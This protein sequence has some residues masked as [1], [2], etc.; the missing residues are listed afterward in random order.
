MLLPKGFVCYDYPEEKVLSLLEK[1][2]LGT[3]G[4]RYIQLDTR[5]RIQQADAPL[6]LCIERH[7]R[8][9][10][11]VTFC[12]RGANWYIRYFAFDALF[13]GSGVKHA[14][15]KKQHGLRAGI[16]DFFNARLDSGEVNRFY[17][18]IDPKNT[19]SLA[20]AAQFALHPVACLITQTFSRIKPNKSERFIQT[21]FE[22]VAPLIRQTY[23][24]HG[25]YFEDQIKHA[26]VAALKTHAIHLEVS[27]CYYSVNWRIERLPGK[28]GG[29]LTRILPVIPVLR[30]L[31]APKHHKFLVVD[32]VCFPLAQPELVEELF[33]SLLADQGVHSLIWWVDQTDGHYQAAIKH[34][35]FGLLDRILGRNQV[36]VVARGKDSKTA[37]DTP[38]FACGFDFI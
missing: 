3:N 37:M 12:K 33:E 18:Y 10:G 34:L 23:G 22:A 26:Q 13:Q 11:N 30:K 5:Q 29:I 28:F 21:N 19:R 24:N 9:I 7:D 32:S 31:I 17:A 15:T 4:A 14:P 8:I 20:M 27:A 35:K 6:F 16:H 2:C 38:H 1:T 36:H 25:F